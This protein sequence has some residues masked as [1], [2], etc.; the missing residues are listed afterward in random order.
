MAKPWLVF[1][2][3]AA[4]GALG[5]H[6]ISQNLGDGDDDGDGDAIDPGPDRAELEQARKQGELEARMDSLERRFYRGY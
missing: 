1:L 2:G 3:G 4:A 5:Y 6:V